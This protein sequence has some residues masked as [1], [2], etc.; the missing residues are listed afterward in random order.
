MG[1]D[2]YRSLEEGVALRVAGLE[3]THAVCMRVEKAIRAQVSH[4]E[5]ISLHCEPWMSTFVIFTRDS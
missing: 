4:V 5:R 3:K 1:P 2:G